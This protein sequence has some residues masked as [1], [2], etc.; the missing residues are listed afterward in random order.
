MDRER[1]FDAIFGDTLHPEV[2]KKSFP[3][4]DFLYQNGRIGIPEF[5]IMWHCA[6]KKHE[7]FKVSIIKALTHIA[8]R[9]SP[10]HTEHL[11]RKIK[12]ISYNEID[13]FTLALIKQ[14]AKRL[15]GV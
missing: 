5:D 12:T 6:T 8:Q 1:L 13:K 15:A 14:L 9:T 7:V 2:I 10:E 3:V 4:L 11:F